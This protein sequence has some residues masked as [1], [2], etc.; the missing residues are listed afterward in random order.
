MFL[1]VSVCHS[2]QSRA[3]AAENFIMHALKA[4]FVTQGDSTVLGK[5]GSNRV[6]FVEIFV[7]H[8]CP[9]TLFLPYPISGHQSVSFDFELKNNY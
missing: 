2:V 4:L 3:Y 1:Q 5:K 9:I 6:T 7:H 8:S